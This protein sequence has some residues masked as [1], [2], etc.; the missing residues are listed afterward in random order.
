MAEVGHFGAAHPWLFGETDDVRRAQD[1]RAALR[2]G[3]TLSCASARLETRPP[4]NA[5]ARG[6]SAE[7]EL[8]V[9]AVRSRA[10][11]GALALRLAD[12]QDGGEAVA[13]RR[14][15]LARDDV[16]GLA[17]QLAVRRSKCPTSAIVTPSSAST[18]PLTSPVNGPASSHA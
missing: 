6:A 15:R 13:Q 12:A 2:N 3:Q 11:P 17:E 7:L 9:L 1:A 5:A 18:A 8:P 16:V 10:A 14:V 4:A